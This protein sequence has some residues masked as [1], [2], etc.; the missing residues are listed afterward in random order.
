MNI[1][2]CLAAGLRGLLVVTANVGE[3]QRVG[4]LLV[5]NWR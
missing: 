5:E 2:G 1:S 3:F 4:G